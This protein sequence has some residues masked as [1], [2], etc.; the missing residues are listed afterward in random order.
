M[1]PCYQL[2]ARYNAVGMGDTQFVSNIGSLFVSVIIVQLMMI[3]AVIMFQLKRST[4]RQLFKKVWLKL[5][6]DAFWVVPIQTLMES[7]MCVVLSSLLV[8]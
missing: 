7:S 2:G 6:N 3:T 8:L 5:K 4:K 1:P